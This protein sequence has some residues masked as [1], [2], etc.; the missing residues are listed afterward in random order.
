MKIKLTLK[1]SSFFFTNDVC[2]VKNVTQEIDTD[3]LSNKDKGIINAYIK[4][5][6]IVCDQGLIVIECDHVIEEDVVV[7]EPEPVIEAPVVVEEVSIEDI[8]QEPEVETEPVVE[9]K[10]KPVAKKG[11]A[12]K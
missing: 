3:I 8:L 7:S 6:A 10:K 11:I 5:G 9:A 4:S 1:Y 2:L 12:K